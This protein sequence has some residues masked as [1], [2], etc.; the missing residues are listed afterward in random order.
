MR[1]YLNGYFLFNLLFIVSAAFYGWMGDYPAAG[2]FLVM[3]L[4]NELGKRLEEAMTEKFRLQQLLF[5]YQLLQA[6][7]AK[8]EPKAPSPLQEEGGSDGRR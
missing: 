7:T 5:R 3:L 1:K 6:L 8:V 2:I 4:V